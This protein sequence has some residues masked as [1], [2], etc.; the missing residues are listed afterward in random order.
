VSIARSD[1]SGVRTLA[2]GEWPSFSADGRSVAHSN[3]TSIH[4]T[5]YIARVTGGRPRVGTRNGYAPVCS[6]DG[7][8]LAFARVTKCGHAVCSGRIFVMPARGGNAQPVGPLVGEPSGP[9]D[10]I[11]D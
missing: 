3:H 1:G 4:G 7:R 8:C 5:I 6:P 10:W 2:R 11:E 9:L